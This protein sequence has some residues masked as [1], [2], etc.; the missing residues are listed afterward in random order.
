MNLL[1]SLPVF[2]KAFEVFGVFYNSTEKKRNVKFDEL[3]R[4]F[5]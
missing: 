1:G 5:S 4:M 2:A 3:Q